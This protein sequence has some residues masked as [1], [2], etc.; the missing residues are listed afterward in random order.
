MASARRIVEGADYAREGKWSSWSPS[1]LLG[2]E[3]QGATLGILGMGRIGMAMARRARGFDMEVLVHNH[4]PR[5][6]DGAESVTFDDLVSRSDFLSLHVPLT[7]KTKHLI[8]KSVFERMKKSAV[9]INTARGGV[10]DHDA[11]YDA[12]KEGR[13]AY[14]ALDVTDPE[15]LPSD[16][17]LYGLKNC[18]IV[19]HLGSSTVVARSKMGVIAAKNLLAGLRGERLPNCVNPEVYEETT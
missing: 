16:H 17:Q 10:V 11:L 3:V 6:V 4:R 7:A 18:L 5:E 8:N 15:P 12:L 19:P 1:L 13:I 2:L 14:A 9:L